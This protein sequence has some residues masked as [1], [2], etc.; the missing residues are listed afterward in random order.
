MP[1]LNI[2]RVRQRWVGEWQNITDY[3][4]LDTVSYQGS[5]YICHTDSS[6]GTLPTVTANWHK[7]AEKGDT[8]ATGP[9]GT[10]GTTDD[11]MIIASAAKAQISG[12]TYTSGVPTS[13]SYSDTTGFTNHTKTISYTNG[14]PTQTVETFDFNSETWTVTTDIAYA[15][16]LPNTKTVGIVKV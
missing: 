12:I 13:I 4:V 10:A 2:G 5:S 1:T 7:I 11:L 16:G 6:A 3:V 15:S 8:G 9:A 14:L